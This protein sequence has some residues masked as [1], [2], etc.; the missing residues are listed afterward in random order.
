[1]RTLINTMLALLLFVSVGFAQT[2]VNL[3]VLSP[4]VV[5][6][7]PDKVPYGT[8]VHLTLPDLEENATPWWR[9][10]EP[11]DLDG[12]NYKILSD[13]SLVLATP[14]SSTKAKRVVFSLAVLR[15]VDGRIPIP[16]EE[17]VII[18]L[19]SPEKEDPV[20]PG[21]PDNPPPTGRFKEIADRAAAYADKVGDPV[22]RNALAEA[23]REVA[24]TFSGMSLD[25]AREATRTT[26]ETVMAANPT[27]WDKP[28][29]EEFRRPIGKM[30]EEL[31]TTA[32]H[33]KGIL[34]I[35]EGLERTPSSNNVR[36]NTTR[37][38]PVIQQEQPRY[39]WEYVC[40]RNGQPCYWRRVRVN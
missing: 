28:W 17:K 20:D 6:E 30:L 23:Y 29:L 16:Q 38:P 7:S 1:M 40:P 8:L 35:A 36:A 18:G 10:L 15:I 31:T 27:A 22:T 25:E 12:A 5:I 11:A 37:G 39:R 14:D 13:G 33:A 9:S 24:S 3:E 26:S 34:A 32:D 2:T 4:N 19:Y 21:D